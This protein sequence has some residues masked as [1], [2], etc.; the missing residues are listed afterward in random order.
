MCTTPY[1]YRVQRK[2]CGV[3]SFLSLDPGKLTEVFRLCGTLFTCWTMSQAQGLAV[4]QVSS[5]HMAKGR[6]A[7]LEFN[8]SCIYNSRTFVSTKLHYEPSIY[9]SRKLWRSSSWGKTESQ[10]TMEWPSILLLT[11][12]LKSDSPKV[13][14]YVVLLVISTPNFSSFFPDKKASLLET[15]ASRWVPTVDVSSTWEITRLV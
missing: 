12:Y 13:V 3:S 10:W 7:T 11:D 6:K 1:P 8:T 14:R 2:T 5:R 4:F 15:L 9:L